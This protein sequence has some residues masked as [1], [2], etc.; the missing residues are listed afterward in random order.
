MISDLLTSSV[1]HHH[2][3]LPSHLHRQQLL[4]LPRR[5]RHSPPLP[6][7]AVRGHASVVAEFA[8]AAGIVVDPPL[9]RSP[10]SARWKRCVGVTGGIGSQWHALLE[11]DVGPSGGC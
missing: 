3:E 2:H 7:P 9:G 11:A 1:V 10:L 6:L 4:L 8:G 5:G